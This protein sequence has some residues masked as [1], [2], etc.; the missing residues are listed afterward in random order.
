MTQRIVR[1]N[2][3]REESRRDRRQSVPPNFLRIA[4]RESP[5][6]NWSPGGFQID[7][8]DLGL[9]AGDGVA[10][11]LRI[12]ERDEDYDFDAQI[13]WTA[14]AHGKAGARFTTLAAGALD[15]LDRALA[16]R[17]NRSRL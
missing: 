3:D 9:A 16:H 14:P 13:A 10:G 11:T 12:A 5:A 15:A 8:G 17:L 2:F 1:T 6:V 4:A 7:P